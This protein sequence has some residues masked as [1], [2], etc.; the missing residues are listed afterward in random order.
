MTD[1][2]KKNNPQD[3]NNDFF[4]L[5]RAEKKEIKKEVKEILKEKEKKSQS[6]NDSYIKIVLTKEEK[7]I[8]FFDRIEFLSLWDKEK[9][10][11]VIKLKNESSGDKLYWI[12]IFL[13]S[14]IATLWLLQNSVAVIIGAMLIAPL[15]RPINWL[16]FSI[17]RW[18]Q[19]FFSKTFH[20]LIF[21]ILL[22]IFMWF[23]ITKTL[24]LDFETTEII[25]RTNPNVI[26]FFIAVFS[27][28]I[29][30][31]SLRFVRLWESIAWVAMA[32]SLMPPLAVIWIELAIWNFFAAFW[33]SMLF[34]TNLIAILLIA[35]IFFWLYWFSPHDTRLQSKVFKRTAIVSFLVILIL[36][37]LFL[38]FNTIKTNNFI[39]KEL[40]IDLSS[41]IGTNL[42]NFEISE[43]SINKNTK[44]KIYVK[45][46]LKIPEW[47]NMD[48][49]LN[50]IYNTLWKEFNKPLSLDIEIIRT[51]NI[52]IDL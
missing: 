50:D 49:V 23:F 11:V 41:I 7:V 35:T 10:D 45:I 52:S 37:P 9:E 48:K 4:D 3:S 34:L 39:S 16:S 40:K 43:I 5:T 25:A 1:L 8:N 51:I 33:A 31:L 18:W 32:A 42:S 19:K 2:N 26:D 6:T 27:A 17:A 21:S 29:A 24:G 15:L 46:V 28:I 20:V 13:S 12:E 38:S 36:I 47:Y 44:E 30:V 22:S 14:S